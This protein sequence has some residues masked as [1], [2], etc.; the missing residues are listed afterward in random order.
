MKILLITL[1]LFFLGCGGMPQMVLMKNA[2][3]G[4]LRECKVDP[5]GDIRHNKQINDCVSLYEKA[6]YEKVQ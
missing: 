2:Q 4:D 5:W 3:S 1:P 6:G